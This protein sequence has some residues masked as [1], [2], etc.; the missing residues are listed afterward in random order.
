MAVDATPIGS[1]VWQTSHLLSSI[2]ICVSHTWVKLYKFVDAEH[3]LCLSY[4]VTF[5]DW[6][7]ACFDLIVEHLNVTD[8]LRR[9]RT[10]EG[11]IVDKE[12]VNSFRS[13][14]DRSRQWQRRHG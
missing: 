11:A 14:F 8:N 9:C 4:S 7:P 6:Y 13:G 3:R 12:G 2:V 5:D 1:F 10:I